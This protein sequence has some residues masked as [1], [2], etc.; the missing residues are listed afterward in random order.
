[1]TARKATR[2]KATRRKTTRKT[3]TR[4]KA[5]RKKA[6][7]KKVARKKPARKKAA[8]KR[9]ARARGLELP[10][11]LAEFRRVVQRDLNVLER[12]VESAGKDARRRITRLVRQASHQLGQLEA[13]GSSQ[14]RK[15]SSKARKE[16]ETTLRRL[17]GAAARG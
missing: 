6:A 12:E 9:A 2:K 10:R 13:R 11:S 17:R 3:T 4:R 1:M 8:R 16:A 14:W 5:T 15:L 7:R